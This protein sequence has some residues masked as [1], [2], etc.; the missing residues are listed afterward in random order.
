[1]RRRWLAIPVLA[2]G[3]ALAGGCAK[4]HARV[5]SP[6]P[7]SVQPPMKREEI[8]AV[9][10]EVGVASWYGVPYDG[11]PAADGEIYHM[12]E[13]VAA[14]RT[15]PFGTMLKVTN[16]SNGRSVKVR[17]IDRGPFVEGR[18]LDLSKEAARRIG[19]TGP[20][21]ARVRLHLVGAPSNL[22]PS[23]FAVQVGAFADRS[24]AETLRARLGSRYGRVR[25]VASAGDPALWRVLVGEAPAIGAARTLAA[26]LRAETGQAFVVSLEGVPQGAD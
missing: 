6:V 1:M 12:R 20:G 2:L 25:L 19:I 18:I 7:P 16:L 17:I 11:R 22:G 13:L 3:C 8:R 15:L 24:R 9:N 10:G 5:A 14:H 21:T 23:L 4:R 26:R